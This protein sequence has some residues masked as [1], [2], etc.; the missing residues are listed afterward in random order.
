MSKIHCRNASNKDFV[1][2]FGDTFSASEGADEGA[3][4]AQFVERMLEQT[5]T[6]DL[7]IFATWDGPDL[8]GAALFQDSPIP[9]TPETS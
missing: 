2:L 6:S 7:R 5:D 8:V 9:K 4:I 1:T 3:T